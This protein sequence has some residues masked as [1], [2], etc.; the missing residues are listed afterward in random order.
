MKDTAGKSANY[1]QTLSLISI[2][3]PLTDWPKKK[4][5]GSHHCL[6]CGVPCP[7]ILLLQT[8]SKHFKTSR[9]KTWSR[10]KERTWRGCRPGGPGPAHVHILPPNP[11]SSSHGIVAGEQENRS[12]PLHHQ[13]RHRGSSADCLHPLAGDERLGQALGGGG[14]CADMGGGQVP[15]TSI[16][17]ERSHFLSLPGLE[18]RS[19][20]PPCP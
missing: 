3:N 11:P 8:N 2:Y 4:Q 19:P 15:D 14:Q 10:T 12:V 1:Y 7:V 9:T 17:L 18:T 6:C 16:T 5:S 20:C 13:R